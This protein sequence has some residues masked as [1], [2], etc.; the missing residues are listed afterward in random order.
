[1][2]S[3]LTVAGEGIEVAL[4]GEGAV[5]EVRQRRGG[6]IPRDGA[7]LSATGEAADWLTEHG[8]VGAI[9]RIETRVLADGKAL[10]AGETAGVVNGG[11]RLVE[12]GEVAIAA[13]AEGFHWEEDPGFYYRFGVRRN[14]R[15]MAG[16]TAD[17]R[18]L[19]V[20]V[21]GRQPGYSVG[22]SFAEGAAIMRALGAAEA[23]S[24]D[25]GGS[26]AMAVGAE[27]VNRPSDPAGER[28][29]VDAIVVL[30]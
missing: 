12:N 5:A 16:V 22:A 13:A 28:P 27:L 25:G 9:L 19:L 10:L 30:P 4:D 21:D 6:E 11:P 18:L 17:G 24:L 14:P 8:A 15:T 3:A 1:M 2:T 20:T 26:T 7:V 29:D 23:V